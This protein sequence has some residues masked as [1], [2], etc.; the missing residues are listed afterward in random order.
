MWKYFVSWM[1]NDT[2]LVRRHQT[3]AP[4]LV[5]NLGVVKRLRAR[6]YYRAPILPIICRGYLPVHL[7]CES[8]A[9]EHPYELPGLI[10]SKIKRPAR[11]LEQLSQLRISSEKDSNGL[12]VS[13]VCMT[14]IQ[15][16]KI[17]NTI[18]VGRDRDVDKRRVGVSRSWNP[19]W[20]WTSKINR[21]D[22]EGGGGA[23]NCQEHLSCILT[24]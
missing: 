12:S 16:V 5:T 17:K 23:T 21:E 8:A 13:V 15:L 20:R 1:L 7:K 18:A 14:I 24:K 2:S 11:A 10:V 6:L 9:F 3:R 4:I 19:G 22:W